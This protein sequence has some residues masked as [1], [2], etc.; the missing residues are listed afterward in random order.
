MSYILEIGKMEQRLFARF[1]ALLL[2]GVFVAGCN[3]AQ[4]TAFSEVATQTH[5]AVTPALM[6]SRF[7]PRQSSQNLP[8]FWVKNNNECSDV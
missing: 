1:I 7:G 6:D 5:S 8:N 2:I 4:K 3:N